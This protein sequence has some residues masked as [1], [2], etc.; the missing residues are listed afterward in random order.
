MKHNCQNKL[1]FVKKYTSL[2]EKIKQTK[3]KANLLEYT[4]FDCTIAGRCNYSYYY[5]VF[6][7][8][9][10][11]ILPGKISRRATKSLVH[12]S[13]KYSLLA[14]QRGQR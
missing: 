9:Q 6:C 5:L 8:L 1:K 4:Y 3:L 14:L 2:L 10:M 7:L 13:L 12:S 11:A